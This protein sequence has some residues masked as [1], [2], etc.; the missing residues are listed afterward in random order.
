MVNR[1][2]TDDNSLKNKT[3]IFADKTVR[4]AAR[5][6]MIADI[7]S[8]T[9][10]ATAPSAIVR[11][12][13]KEIPTTIKRGGTIDLAISKVARNLINKI[14]GRTIII[15]GPRAVRAVRDPNL[16]L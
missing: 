13:V 6:A 4:Q 9:R 7:E 8:T 5:R 11:A 16:K 14:P 10:K 2:F 12:T 15:K 1:S 3:G